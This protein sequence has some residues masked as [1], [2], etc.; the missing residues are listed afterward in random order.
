L[1]PETDARLSGLLRA[2]LAGDEAAYAR[3]LREVAEIVRATAR[4][5]LG[6]SSEPDP[7][8]IVQE[9]LLAIH[10]KRHTW[11]EDA[12]IGP[13]V[14][15]IAR[16]KMV[17]AFRRRGRAVTVDIEE[18]AESLAGEEAQLVIE[19]DVERALG[20]LTEGQR[21]VVS[22]ISL[23]GRSITETA[24]QLG[25]NENAVRVALHRGLAAIARHFG[26]TDT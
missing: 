23:E 13:W 10:L 25:M 9:T 18:L 16:Y 8:D 15:A 24:S 11:R 14:H 5:R 19:R 4:R 21:Q 2:A 1:S 26:N 7:E 17:D 12:P 22:A 20:C 3:F 6:R